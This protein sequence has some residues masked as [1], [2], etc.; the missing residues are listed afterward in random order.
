VYNW[1]DYIAKDTIP[2]FTRQTGVQVKYDNYDSDDTLQ[3]KLLTG[4]SGY[5]IVVPTSNYAG[6]Q[7]AAGIF[8]P[9]DKSKLP[10]LK[11]LDPSLMALVAGADP[12]N[13]FTVPWAYGTTVPWLQRHQ[14]AADSRQE[15]AARQL[16][17]PLQAGKHFEAEGLRRLRARRAGSDVRRRA[18]PHR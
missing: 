6:K 1:S 13:K 8:A 7:I 17:R 10:N 18:A 9:L 4:N 16:G 11:Y 3:A 15:R 12:G 14:G 2:N 5:D